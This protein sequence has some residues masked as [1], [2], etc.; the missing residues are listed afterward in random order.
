MYSRDSNDAVIKV[1]CIKY[2]KIRNKDIKQRYNRL[3]AKSDNKIK[4]QHET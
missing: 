4:K 3:I 2:Y 1:F